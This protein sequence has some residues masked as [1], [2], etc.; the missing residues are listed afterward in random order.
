MMRTFILLLA[1]TLWLSIHVYGQEKPPETT[2][3]A[4]KEFKDYKWDA[5]IGLIGWVGSFGNLMI[6]YAPKSKGAYRFSL[7]NYDS[8][9]GKDYYY[10]DSAGNAVPY[11]LMD[12]FNAAATLGYE[13][14]RNSGKHQLFYGADFQ[15]SYHKSHDQ[16][17][18]PFPNQ[19][20][21]FGLNPFAGIKYRII[22]RLSISA[23][24]A[25]I[26]KYNIEQTLHADKETTR[27]RTRYFNTYFNAVRIINVTYHL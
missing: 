9:S 15:F 12:N 3:K 18:D 22:N 21:G 24:T 7:E 1:G 16:R 2:K 8:S 11:R 26:F 19:T 27:S 14:R 6:R 13:F 25:L 5:S 4:S 23:E 10:A 20:Y 17:Y